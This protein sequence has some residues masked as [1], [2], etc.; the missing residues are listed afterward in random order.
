MISHQEMAVGP[1]T[2]QVKKEPSYSAILDPYD[3]APKQIASSSVIKSRC[4]HSG[5]P[6]TFNSQRDL[7]SHLFS[8]APGLAAEYKAMTGTMLNLIQMVESWDIKTP[9]EKV[10]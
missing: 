1:T 8:H 10:R 9:K 3:D 5:C 6:L 2:D 4:L 7:R